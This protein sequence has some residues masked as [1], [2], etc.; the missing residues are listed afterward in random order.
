MLRTKSVDMVGNNA[1]SFGP[2]GLKFGVCPWDSVPHK[3]YL[4][5]NCYSMFRAKSVDMVGTSSACKR[6]K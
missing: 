4:E 6:P 3:E 2:I 5:P 1:V